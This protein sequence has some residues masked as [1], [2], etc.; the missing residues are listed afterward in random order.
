MPAKHMTQNEIT[1]L[2]WEACAEIVQGFDMDEMPGLMDK[3]I[4]AIDGLC[5]EMREQANRLRAEDAFISD[6]NVHSLEK[7][8]NTE[9]L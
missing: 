4:E 5:D 7:P 3:T 2:A 9:E 1:A 6:M 8:T